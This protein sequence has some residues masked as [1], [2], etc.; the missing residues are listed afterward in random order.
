MLPK[1]ERIE[2]PVV[3]TS[4][5]HA[6]TEDNGCVSASTSETNE[7]D[8]ILKNR[9]E[10]SKKESVDEEEEAAATSV[11]CWLCPMCP[12]VYKKHSHFKQHLCIAHE[13]ETDDV[14]RIVSVRMT[15]ADFFAQ[16]EAANRAE[17]DFAGPA[18]A[19]ARGKRASPMVSGGGGVDS[20]AASG[21][22]FQ[23]K[24]NPLAKDWTP[25]NS[26]ST[27]FT[28]Y[29]CNEQF[30]KDY[31]LKLHLMLN[32]KS[33]RPEDMA[34]AKEE[35]TKSKLDGC[36][37]K[38]AMCGSRYNSVA[39]FTRHIKDVHEMNRAHYREE[40]GSAEI[41][42]RT[43]K[44]ELCEKVLGSGIRSIFLLKLITVIVLS[45]A[46]GQTYAQHHCRPHEDGSP[47]LVERVSRDTN[48]DPSRGKCRRPPCS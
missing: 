9:L 1:V 2:E 14:A 15:E 21:G 11:E 24:R 10:E 34:K 22:I 23:G 38:C 17:E 5:A 44:C 4:D 29:F 36:V 19:T 48:Q 42:S 45:I 40:Y 32:H 8:S 37:Y 43:F 26:F 39:N 25:A 20:A 6:Q 41:V 18:A 30:R 31:K 46:G 13:M 27:T 35:L 28:C 47:D 33:E 16:Q 7:Q 3:S 12:K